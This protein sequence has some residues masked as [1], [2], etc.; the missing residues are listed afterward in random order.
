MSD[1][2]GI[3]P[4]GWPKPACDGLSRKEVTSLLDTELI[5]MKLEKKNSYSYWA[6]EV[7]LDRYWNGHAKRVDFV[8]FEPRGG[9]SYTDGAHVELGRF[10]FYEVKSCMADLRSGNGLNFEGDRNYLV[11]PV[12]L[13][14][15]FKDEIIG[16]P[17]GYVAKHT[18]G[19]EC[20]L[21]GIGPNGKPKFWETCMNPHRDSETRTR[22]ASEL[23]LC[24][25][26]AMLAN[27][28]MAD[29][30][31]HIERIREEQ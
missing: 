25:M 18:Q 19:A 17:N 20:L 29:I 16:T 9:Q 12:E 24:M 5:R 4:Y 15:P 21:Y 26:R 1:F 13:W 3:Y 8:Q 7:W 11:V 6:H 28:G 2:E 14:E 22:S 23:L 27:S 31:R 30:N 10:T